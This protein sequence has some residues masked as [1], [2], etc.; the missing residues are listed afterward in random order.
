M[1]AA[2]GEAPAAA[3]T[4]GSAAR[5]RRRHDRKPGGVDGHSVATDGVE[6]WRLIGFD[7]PEIANAGCE[8]ERSVGILGRQRLE[9]PGAEASVMEV[10][11]S[12]TRHRHR[13]PLGDLLL[14]GVSVRDRMIAELYARPYN[15]GRKNG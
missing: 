4:A 3:G 13:W 10:V 9:Q 6:L 7:A 1:Q 15:G 12:G 11:D 2:A 5:E 8:G 14:D